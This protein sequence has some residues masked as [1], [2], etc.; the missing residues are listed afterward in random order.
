MPTVD[1]L[2]V[3]NLVRTSFSQRV[4]P[5]KATNSLELSSDEQENLKEIFQF[6]WKETSAKDWERLSDV[7]SWFSP[8]AFCYYLPG[9]IV[10]SI[11]ENC[12]TL[13]AVCNLLF[14]LDR[15]PSLE[16]WDNFFFER[17][18]LLNSQELEAVAT[19]IHWLS[20][21]QGFILDDI[22]LTRVL[23]NIDLLIDRLKN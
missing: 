10:A 19:W 5:V 14:M 21:L 15:T 17:W 13:T 4:R 8:E 9:I 16:L 1:A 23:L 3:S 6:S 12:P 11:E 20:G 18:T 22:S 7:V 2:R